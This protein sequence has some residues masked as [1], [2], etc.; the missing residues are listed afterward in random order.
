MGMAS[1]PFLLP[2]LAQVNFEETTEIDSMS[3]DLSGRIRV[4]PEFVK[5]QPDNVLGG[6]IAHNLMH[7][8][9]F[10]TARRHSRDAK[11]WDT[12]SDMAINQI[13][14]EGQVALPAD[15]VY[16]PHGLRQG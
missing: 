9:M 3:V 15:A 16:P 8:M 2:A 14:R 11:T 10:H 7:L 13:L 4:N 5:M 6:C 1:A 12:A